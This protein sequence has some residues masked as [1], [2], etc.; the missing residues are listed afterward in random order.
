MVKRKKR[1]EKQVKG[2]EKQKKKHESKLNKKL[3]IHHMDYDKKNNNEYN[4]IP[5]CNKC[6]SQTN[7][8][9]GYWIQYFKKKAA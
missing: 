8:N 2:L 7:F 3:A 6:H 9:R 1:L 4:L 5:L